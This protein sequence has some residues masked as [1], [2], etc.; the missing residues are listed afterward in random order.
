MQRCLINVPGN[1]RRLVERRPA[2]L[3]RDL[4]EKQKRQLLGACAEPC[5]SIVAIRQPVIAKDVAV[6][7][8]FLNELVR[9]VID[10]GT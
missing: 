4:K 6:V 9:V 5:R 10:H 1:R 3:V 7:P 8:E 2:L